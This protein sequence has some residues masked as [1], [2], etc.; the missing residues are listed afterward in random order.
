MNQARGSGGRAGSLMVR[1]V[2]AEDVEA[3]GALVYESFY[4][5]ATKHGHEPGYESV[6]FATLVVNI[7]S[8]A[9]GFASFL[10]CE[11]GEPVAV[12]F[13][14]ERNEIAGVGPVAVSVRHQG[15][16]LGRLVMEAL[17]ER[18]EATGYQSVRLLQSAYNCVS[19]SL[20]TRLGFDVKDGIATLRGRPAE[21]ERPSGEVRD[22]TPADLD[23]LDELSLEVVGFR[24]R[25]DIEISRSLAPPLV[26]ERQGRI[27]GF[28]CW[29]PTP[30]GTLLAPAVA[31]DEQ[32]L[33]DLILGAARS[34]TVGLIVPLPLSYASVL[35]WALDGGFTVSEL[36][37]LM[38]R[39]SYE[40]PAG[41]Y[42]PSV[43]Y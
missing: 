10:A 39:G 6:E 2:T 18:T 25:G 37:T 28:T 41:A 42:L 22:G 16:G 19:F 12:N 26:V 1:A 34:T 30:G 24:R 33:R 32:A 35:R 21:G 29:F 36:S 5:V 3:V 27:A 9:E 43:W 23:A 20:Y 31:R 15:R 4:D 13:L 14:D 17:L 40:R 7:L 8:Q 11:G 38:V